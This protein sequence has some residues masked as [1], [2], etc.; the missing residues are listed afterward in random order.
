M[1]I[2]RFRGHR[3]AN[4]STENTRGTHRS[5]KQPIKGIIAIK[6]RLVTSS[7]FELHGSSI[8]PENQ[9]TSKNRPRLFATKPKDKAGRLHT[10][11]LKATS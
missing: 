5:K 8:A 1:T 4:G 11:P 3:W 10:K 6:Y 2:L 9:G 7:K